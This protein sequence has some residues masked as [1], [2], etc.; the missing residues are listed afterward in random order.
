MGMY[1]KHFNFF[2]TKYTFS[3]SFEA[4]SSRKVIKKS[5]IGL[6]TELPKST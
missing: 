3:D 1:N 2:V 5:Q 6:S 4:T